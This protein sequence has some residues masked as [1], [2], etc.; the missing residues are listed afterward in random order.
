[1]AT[2]HMNWRKSAQADPAALNRDAPEDFW[3][4]LFRPLWCTLDLTTSGC[5]QVESNRMEKVATRQNSRNAALSV[6]PQAAK[7][8]VHSSFKS[9]SNADKAIA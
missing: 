9:S 4:S 8:H 6:K 2:K 3:G 5:F 7:G 1:V